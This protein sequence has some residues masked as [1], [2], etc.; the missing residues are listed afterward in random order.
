MLRKAT[1]A[2]VRSGRSFSKPPAAAAL[3]TEAAAA[4]L[5]GGFPR[6]RSLHSS[7][8]SS[9]PADGTGAIVVPA[10]ASPGDAVVEDGLTFSGATSLPQQADPTLLQSRVVV[11][12][13]VCHLCHAGVNWVIRADKHQKVKFCCLQSKAAEPYLKLCGLDREDVLKRFLFVEGLYSYHQASTA[14]LRVLSYL[15][16][17]YSAL[18]MLLVIPSPLRDLIYDYVAKRR[19]GWFG[20]EE[21]CIIVSEEQMLSR[22]ID[23]DELRANDEDVTS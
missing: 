19:Y 4:R 23:R 7:S 22:F 18:S 20:K 2:L 1:Q 17:P 9:P 14:A 6:P 15:P 10:S 8:R 21:K 13:G 11:Y 12:D 3:S 5:R 16:F